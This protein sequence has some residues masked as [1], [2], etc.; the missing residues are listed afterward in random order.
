VIAARPTKL[1][2]SGLA[3]LLLLGSPGA[4][5]VVVE[6]SPAAFLLESSVTSAA[7]P[8]AVYAAL[9][10]K[11]GQW[12]DPI[13]TGSGVARNLSIEPRAGGCFCERLADG[14]SVQHARVILAEPGKTLR[15]EGGFDPLQDMAVSAVL[16]FTREPAGAGTQI[17]LTYRVAGAFT[18]D[19][20]KLAPLVDM[21]CTRQLRRLAAFAA[22]GNPE[23]TKARESH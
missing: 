16:T 7:N 3:T 13:H 8:A 10:R 23:D 1:G 21:V 6:A 17:T 19:S 14:G 15:L 18:V 11:V 4:G 20:A 5:A 22:T 9:A 12:W 2:L